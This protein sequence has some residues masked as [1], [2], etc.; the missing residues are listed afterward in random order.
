MATK[1]EKREHVPI[2]NREIDSTFLKMS[3]INISS[4]IIGMLLYGERREAFNFWMDPIS[5]LG[6]TETANGHKNTASL[7]VFVLGMVISGLLMLRIASL[8]RR[9]EEIQHHRL[10]S[11]LS[12]GAALGFFIITYPCNINNNIHSVGG[13]LLFGDLWGI[14]LLFLLEVPSIEG[15]PHAVLYHFILHS[16]VLTYAFNFVI[17]SNIQ[18]I[19]QKF[20][21]LSLII[22]LKATTSLYRLYQEPETQL[23]QEDSGLKD[24]REPE[25]SEIF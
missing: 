10:K 5:F 1:R 6:A 2:C 19:T 11:Y 7:I 17:K 4:M 12:I 14:T 20:A 8:F 18:Q 16:T 24:S 23:S 13:A 3:V 9:H 25:E 15:A 21:I 22:V